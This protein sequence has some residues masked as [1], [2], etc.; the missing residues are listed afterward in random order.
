MSEFL[1]VLIMTYFLKQQATRTFRGN[2][3]NHT[4]TLE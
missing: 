2:E 4:S 3:G 1:L